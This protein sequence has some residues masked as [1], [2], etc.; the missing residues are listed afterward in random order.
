MCKDEVVEHAQ[1]CGRTA[2]LPRGKEADQQHWV[3]GVVVHALRAAVHLEQLTGS[4]CRG[5]EVQVS[6]AE[7][8]RSLRSRGQE[9]LD[10]E[11]GALRLRWIT[12]RSGKE[13]GVGDRLRV[14]QPFQRPTSIPLSLE[15]A[16]DKPVPKRSRVRTVETSMTNLQNQVLFVQVDRCL[17]LPPKTAPKCN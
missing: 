1:R 2:L 14:V 5:N 7:G 8:L 4:H 16:R 11:T 10:E 15:C 6:V 12:T 9:T 13:E 17:G 3:E